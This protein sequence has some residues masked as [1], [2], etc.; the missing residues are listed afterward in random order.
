VSIGAPGSA[1]D[2][3]LCQFERVGIGLSLGL[4]G[5]SA[6]S[7]NWNSLFLLAIGDDDRRSR[8]PL[9]CANFLRVKLDA[10]AA[11]GF[12]S[13]DKRKDKE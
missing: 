5:A 11:V 8:D 3:Q 12:R 13:H 6:P 1:V 10:V 9:A 4:E 2:P 7:K